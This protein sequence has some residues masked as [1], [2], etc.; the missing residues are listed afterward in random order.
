[1][2][3]RS[4]QT[5]TCG[6]HTLRSSPF[7]LLQKRNK[8]GFV[9]TNKF[10]AAVMLA[11][12]GV[13]ATKLPLQLLKYF[14]SLG[15]ICS[16]L[17]SV[18]KRALILWLFL[19]C[20]VNGF[21]HFFCSIVFFKNFS[22]ESKFFFLNKVE[23]CFI[24]GVDIEDDDEDDDPDTIDYIDSDDGNATTKKVNLCC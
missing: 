19:S 16:F 23:A 21:Q 13:S 4:S 9:F 8:N 20:P 14:L 11:C 3:T 24:S 12:K 17:I 18:L 22:F 5:L 2:K 1:M 6:I 10:L 7:I 15:I